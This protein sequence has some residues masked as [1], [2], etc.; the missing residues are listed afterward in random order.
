MWERDQLFIDGKWTPPISALESDAVI[1]VVSP[2]SEAVIGHAACAG[3]ADV[4]RAVDAAR[5]AFDTG[6]CEPAAFC[7]VRSTAAIAS[8]RVMMSANVSRPSRHHHPQ[9]CDGCG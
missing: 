3:P 9:R 5:A 6:I 7:A 4:G 8:L 2:H 1:T